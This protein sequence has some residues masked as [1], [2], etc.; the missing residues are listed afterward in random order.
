MA[1]VVVQVEEVVQVEG[2]VVPCMIGIKQILVCF[3]DDNRVPAMTYDDDTG[4]VVLVMVLLFQSF[5][6]SYHRCRTYR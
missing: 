1:V 3:W 6:Q 2:V 5:L 4:L